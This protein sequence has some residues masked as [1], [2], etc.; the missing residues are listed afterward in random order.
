MAVHAFPPYLHNGSAATLEDVLELVPHRTAGTAGVDLLTSA[1]DRAALATFLRSIDKSV[2]PFDIGPHSE[3]DD[4]E[5]SAARG[6]GTLHL[7]RV[8][9]NP[10]REGSTIAFSL[11]KPGPVQIDIYNVLGQRVVDLVNEVRPAGQHLV[12]WDGRNSD[13]TKVWSGIYYVRVQSESETA[14]SVIVILP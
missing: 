6:T 7:D 12:Q 10:T 1:A 3:L 5:R 9:P 4:S 13:G 8:Y 14:K 2:Q 11:P